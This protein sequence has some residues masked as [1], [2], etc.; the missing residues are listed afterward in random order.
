MKSE[1]NN[2]LPKKQ[3]FSLQQ[4]LSKWEKATDSEKASREEMGASVTLF[5]DGIR[6]LKKNRLAMGSFFVLVIMLAVILFAP[7]IVPYSYDEILTINGERDIGAQNLKP[8]TFSETEKAYIAQGNFRFPHLMG[9]DSQCRDYFIRVVYGTRISFMVGIFAS[10]IV[11]I[12]GL[13]FGSI[14]GYFGGFADMLIMRI[15]DIIYSVPDMLIIIL[16]SVALNESINLQGIPVLENL[17]TNMLS[18]FLVFGL[19][20]WVSMARLIRGQILTV[21]QNDYVTA[22]YNLGAKPGWIIR[23]HILPNCLSII[24]VST[25]LEI[26]SAIFTES[27]LSFIGLG[28]QAPMPSLGSL[29]NTAM[30]AITTYPFQMIFPSLVICLIVLS[31]N[32][33]GDGLRDAFDPKLKR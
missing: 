14:A 10:L 28:V 29:A 22:A 25:T 32:L 2:T 20:Y 26:P 15:V 5:K 9:T 18:M 7:I 1:A 31:L 27:Y 13:F 21:K 12:V 23:K 6:K 33:L 16:L 17:G 3:L 24:I 4:D 30:S 8:L 11:L 19:F